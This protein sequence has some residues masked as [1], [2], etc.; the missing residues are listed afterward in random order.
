MYIYI[1]QHFGKRRYTAMRKEYDSLAEFYRDFA[2][3]GS[4]H[5]TEHDA[6]ALIA[7]LKSEKDAEATGFPGGGVTVQI[8]TRMSSKYLPQKKHC[9]AKYTKLSVAIR[10]EDAAD[11]SDA[12][13]KL[14]RRQADVIMPV[15]REVS[16]AAKQQR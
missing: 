4:A 15:I 8:P 12:C 2:G 7:K 3:E 14:G 5:V 10:K 13:R 11:F 1:N 16:A 6:D 9:K